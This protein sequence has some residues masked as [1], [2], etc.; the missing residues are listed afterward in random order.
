MIHKIKINIIQRK[1]IN[2]FL[3]EI[4]YNLRIKT[5]NRF[6]VNNNPLN[7]ATWIIIDGLKNDSLN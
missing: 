7:N 4:G 2:Y 1:Y 3:V 6:D 5:M